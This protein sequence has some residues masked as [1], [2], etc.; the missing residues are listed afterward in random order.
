MRMRWKAGVVLLALGAPAL[1]LAVSPG[2]SLYVK[3]KNTRVMKSPSPTADAMV[4]LQPGQQVVWNGA[5]PANKQWHKV[6]APG[7]KQGFV[8]QTNLSTTPPRMELVAKDGNARQVDPAAFVASGAAVKALSP[9]AEQYSKEKGGDYAQSAEQLK[10]LEKLARD[11]KPAAIARHV[12]D[13]ELFPV[14][15]GSEVAGAS[16]SSAAKKKGGA[17]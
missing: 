1:A 7:G 12:T 6:T 4:V 13:A 14:V 16:G 8:F 11:I 2:G 15:G 17:R 3:A 10:Q 5:E 9:G